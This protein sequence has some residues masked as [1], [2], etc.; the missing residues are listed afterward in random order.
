MGHMTTAAK[1]H[2]IDLYREPQLSEGR[3]GYLCLDRNERVTPYEK[4]FLDE[5]FAGLDPS[6]ICS[7]PNPKP[8]ILQQRIE[9]TKDLIRHVLKY[10]QLSH[11]PQRIKDWSLST[12]H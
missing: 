1:K 7:Y 6:L 5:F 9:R 3:G 11:T 12:T 8:L 4:A 2:L 10:E